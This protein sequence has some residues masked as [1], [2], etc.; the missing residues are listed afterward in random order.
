MPLN[1]PLRDWA[2]QCVWLVGASSGIGMALA[3]ALHEQGACVVV[4]ARR[5][6]RLQQFV[7]AH[8]GSHALPLDVAQADQVA[9]AMDHVLKLSPQGRLDMVV[10]AAAT[11]QPMRATA[12]DLP[13]ALAHQ[14]INV[15]GAWHVLASV[16]PVLTRQGRGHVSLVASVAGYRGLPQSLAYGPTK[17]ALINLAEALYLDLHGL[18][19]GVS[20]INPGFVETELTARNDFK[21]PAIMPA[22]QAALRIVEGWKRGQFEIDFPKRFTT[23]LK[24]MRL[25]PHAWYFA[26]VRRFTGT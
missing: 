15:E 26:L 18:G 23:W 25:M 10:F 12:I 3:H 14:R 9:Q 21:M 11:Y 6:E 20:V 19:I 24:L 16:V 2:G 8:P 17:A 5:A 1:P 4:S 22:D 13:Q 7:Q